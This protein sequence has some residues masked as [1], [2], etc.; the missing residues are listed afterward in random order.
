MRVPNHVPDSADL[1]IRDTWQDEETP[2]KASQSELE[3]T[4]FK[5][6]RAWQPHAWKVRFLRRSVPVNRRFLSSSVEL[7]RRRANATCP[8]YVPNFALECGHLARR[9]GPQRAAS[10]GLRSR[11]PDGQGARTAVVRE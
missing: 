2:C 7:A 11:L 5:T 4:L 9:S 6:G 8:K 3:G 1:I 10:A